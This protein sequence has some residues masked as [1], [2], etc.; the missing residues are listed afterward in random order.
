MAWT[1][2]VETVRT[3]KS[4][5]RKNQSECSDLPCHIIIV[6]VVD[7]VIIIDI[8]TWPVTC[9][10][11]LFRL[12]KEFKCH[13]LDLQWRTKS[14]SNVSINIKPVRGRGGPKGFVGHLTSIAFLT[15]RNLPKNLRPRVGTFAFLHGGMGPSLCR[16]WFPFCT[17]LM[18]FLTIDAIIGNQAFQN[19]KC[20]MCFSLG[21]DKLE[22]G[23]NVLMELICN[24]QMLNFSYSHWFA[25]S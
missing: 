14:G 2:S 18:P 12:I 24:H 19:G 9:T 7:I 5:P 22:A 6:I 15:L 10:C 1:V 20:Y 3:V 13:H 8:V 23:Y 25:C 16:H 21:L 11:T 17:W 4:R